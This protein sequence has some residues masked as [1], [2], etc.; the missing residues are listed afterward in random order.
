MTV[1]ANTIANVVAVVTARTPDGL[2]V[3]QTHAVVAW[4]E[5]STH[6]LVPYVMTEHGAVRVDRL[7]EH[8]SDGA[9][10]AGW[11][12]GILQEHPLAPTGLNGLPRL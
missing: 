4:A 3:Q 8:L 6:L 12:V 10:L 9:Y 11:R 7:D 2:E 5:M 1:I